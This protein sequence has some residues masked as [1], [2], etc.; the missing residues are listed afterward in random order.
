MANLTKVL[1]CVSG[2]S[3]GGYYGCSMA[4]EADGSGFITRNVYS[5]GNRNVQR[6]YFK[7]EKEL[8]KI[9]GYKKWKNV[10]N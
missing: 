7:N 8:L 2:F 4:V 9:I 3:V 10:S 1:K 5:A 6:V